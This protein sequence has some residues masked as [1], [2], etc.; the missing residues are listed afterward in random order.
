[1]A[2]YEVSSIP[3]F[4]LQVPKLYTR[5]LHAKMANIRALRD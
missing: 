2:P 1:M 4:I 5:M 3:I